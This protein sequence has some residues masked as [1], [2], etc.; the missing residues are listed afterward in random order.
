MVKYNFDYDYV[1]DS[2][3]IFNKESKVKYSIELDD[4]YVLDIDFDGNIVGVE[5]FNASKKFNVP[6]KF[7]RKI[8]RVVLNTKVGM[9]LLIFIHLYFESE[10][11]IKL[12]QYTIA[13][14]RA[15]A[16]RSKK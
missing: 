16:V 13:I 15:V 4:D 3:Y 12:P 2:L 11:G 7:L 14:P 8:K 1:G 6:K 10:V 5:V 9:M